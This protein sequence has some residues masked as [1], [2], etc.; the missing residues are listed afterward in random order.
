MSTIPV[1]VMVEWAKVNQQPLMHQLVVLSIGWATFCHST[2]DGVHHNPFLFT[3]DHCIFFGGFVFGCFFLGPNLTHSYPIHLL[4]L[5]S[6]VPS[7]VPY[8]LSPTNITIL[9]TSYPTD[10]ITILTTYPTNI[11]TMLTT[12]L[13]NLTSLLT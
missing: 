13:I 7:L 1:E 3:V 6:I 2:L 5:I 11:A 4:T 8:L 12:Y 9:I 10:L